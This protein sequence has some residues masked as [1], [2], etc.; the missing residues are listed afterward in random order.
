MPTNKTEKVRIKTNKYLI[1]AVASIAWVIFHVIYYYG[2]LEMPKGDLIVLQM[3]IEVY[4]F[5]LFVDM[6][7]RFF[8]I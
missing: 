2:A 3:F 5:L 1:Y 8:S 7:L 6:S 4:I